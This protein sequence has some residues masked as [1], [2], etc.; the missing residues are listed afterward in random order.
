MSMTVMGRVREIFLNG[1]IRSVVVGEE[2]GSIYCTIFLLVFLAFSLIK[3]FSL[4]WKFLLLPLQ[5]IYLQSMKFLT[6]DQ[7]WTSQIFSC[8]GTFWFVKII[9][10]GPFHQCCTLPVQTIFHIN[11]ACPWINC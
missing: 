8:Q 7:S 3:C 1:F 5:K 2:V 6:S 11:E 4:A 9:F 10:N